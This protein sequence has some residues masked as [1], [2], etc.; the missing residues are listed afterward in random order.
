MKKH[1]R[2]YADYCINIKEQTAE[3][4]MLV[5]VRLKLESIIPESFG[6]ADCVVFNKKVL[7]IID[8]KY[9]Q[10]VRVKAHKNEQLMVYAVGVIERFNLKPHEIHLCIFQP[11]ID[12]IDTYKMDFIELEKFKEETLKPNALKAFNGEGEKKKGE[13]C[14]FCKHKFNCAEFLKVGNK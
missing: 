9:G 12:N 5:E 10:G 11:R 6:T 2:A 3:S 8:F 4:V 13:W 7:Y 1:A 14:K